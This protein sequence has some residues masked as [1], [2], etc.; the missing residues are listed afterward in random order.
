LE[1]VM[2]YARQILDTYV[3]DARLD[4]GILGDTI[5]ALND[6]IQACVVD[7]DADLSEPD[8]ADMVKCVRLCLHCTDIC[9]AAAAVLSRPAEYDANVV[10]PLLESCVAICA[11]CGDECQRHAHSHDHCRLCEAACRRCEQACRKF[12]G[13]I[14]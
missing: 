7:A 14:V 2:S 8:L 5:D 12:L 9:T 4:R 3:F 10:R 6:C 11:S 1:G 13:A